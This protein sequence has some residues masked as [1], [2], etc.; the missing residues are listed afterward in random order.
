MS[1]PMDS[2]LSKQNRKGLKE[3]SRLLRGSLLFYDNDSFL[4]H[5]IEVV[6]N[7]KKTQ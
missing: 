1:A 6:Y 2:P 5:Y 3:Q 4:I 7:S